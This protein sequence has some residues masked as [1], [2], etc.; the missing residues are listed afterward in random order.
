[1]TFVEDFYIEIRVA[2]AVSVINC[3]TIQ[4]G[5]PVGKAYGAGARLQLKSANYFT[6]G[7]LG[8]LWQ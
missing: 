7:G 1:M 8:R 2:K 3:E 4:R 5:S 6:A